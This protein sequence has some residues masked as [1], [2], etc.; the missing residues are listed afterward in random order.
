MLSTALD[1]VHV[2]WEFCVSLDR[3]M[4]SAHY[5]SAIRLADCI[6]FANRSRDTPLALCTC[7][8]NRVRLCL[9]RQAFLSAPL[10]KGVGWSVDNKH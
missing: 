1:A 3:K 9:N 8:F 5:V 6:F 7:T 4:Y 10:T 2:H